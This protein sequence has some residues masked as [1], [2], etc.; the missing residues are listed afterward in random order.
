M[1]VDVERL[2]PVT[3]PVPA[4]VDYLAIGG[5]RGLAAARERGPEWVLATV[6]RSGL[7]ERAGVGLPAASVWDRG[8]IYVSVVRQRDRFIIA[9]NPYQLLEGLMIAALAV[10]ASQTVIAVEPCLEAEIAR[11][12][13]ALDETAA[14]GL[15]GPA[16]VRL[17]LDTETCLGD[18]DIE[19]LAHVPE[20]CRRGPEW[21]QA[22]ETMVFSVSGDVRAPGVVELPIGISVR[23]LV[24]LVA[25]GVRPGLRGPAAVVSEETG[26]LL[27]E[28]ELDLP[29]THG[30]AEFVVCADQKSS[31]ETTGT[32]TSTE[33]PSPGR[34]RIVS[35]PP[36][37]SA[38]SAMLFSP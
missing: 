5:G 34:E 22:N 30:C 16:S 15:L 37:S 26:T 12:C 17:L 35:D 19:G 3:E 8:G 4:L 9:R 23:M 11:L 27:T 7:R 38:R 32:A 25:G 6:E 21:F 18:C 33:V 1:I 20:I 2:F 10:G 29:I 28:D 31:R 24:N 14:A 36:I 13:D